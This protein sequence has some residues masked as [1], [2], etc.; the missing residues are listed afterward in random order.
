MIED[1]IN[2]APFTAFSQWLRDRA[3]DVA[4]WDLSFG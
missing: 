2:A 1:I 3:Y 4:L